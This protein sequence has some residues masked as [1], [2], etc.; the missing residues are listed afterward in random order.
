[1]LVK[2]HCLFRVLF[3]CLGV[4]ALAWEPAPPPEVKPLIPDF[5]GVFDGWETTA[6][7]VGKGNLPLEVNEHGAPK[8]LRK[9][10]PDV[11]PGESIPKALPGQPGA[12]PIIQP[13]NEEGRA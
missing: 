12:Q 2:W 13:A 10:A 6:A 4:A 8:P 7:A 1:M 3:I 11:P 5:K 9:A